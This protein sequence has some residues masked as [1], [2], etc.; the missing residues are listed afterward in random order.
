MSC[1]ENLTNTGF[2]CRTP[3]GSPKNLKFSSARTAIAL[4]SVKL[5]ATWDALYKADEATRVYPMEI[6]VFEPGSYEQGTEE[7]N[8]KTIP[9]SIKHTP[10]TY[11]IA[12]P[13]DY[14]YR[15]LLFPAGTTYREL[16]IAVTTDKNY[17]KG[18]ISSDGLNFEF[19]KVGV[20]KLPEK[21]GIDASDKLLFTIQELEPERFDEMLSV[22]MGFIS[23]E[24]AGLKDLT[25]SLVSA[26]ITEIVVQVFP[27]G[28]VFKTT[29]ITDL[30]LADFLIK[31][32][33]GTTITPTLVAYDSTTEAYTLTGTYITAETSTTTLETPATMDKLYDA[34]NVLDCPVPT[35]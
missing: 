34:S 19:V 35:P 32:A 13:D 26:S 12:N 31:A 28:D 5:E 8:F 14:D 10:D 11:K 3:K 6:D 7:L 18:L 22:P 1:N 21:G 9:T 29:P 15:N 25:L 20:T 27:T 2:L 4:T 33:A 16:Y 30:V 17:T 24:D 23:S